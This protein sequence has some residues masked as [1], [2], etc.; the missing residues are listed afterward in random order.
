M[1][2]NRVLSQSRGNMASEWSSGVEMVG[3]PN[4]E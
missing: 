1:E 4:L 3:G 2:G